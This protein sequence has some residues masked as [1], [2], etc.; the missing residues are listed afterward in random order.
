MEVGSQAGFAGSW[1]LRRVSLLRRFHGRED[2]H[3]HRVIEAGRCAAESVGFQLA[4]PSAIA[5]AGLAKG[6]RRDAKCMNVLNQDLTHAIPYP[7]HV[8]GRHGKIDRVIV[9]TSA[10]PSL[11]A[12][13]RR[14]PT[15]HGAAQLQGHSAM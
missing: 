7:H 3:G 9:V 11:D 14:R 13:L 1:V 4:A 2:Q 10:H 6:P 12:V 8:L 5:E 15:G